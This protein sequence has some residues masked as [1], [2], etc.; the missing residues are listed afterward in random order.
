[1]GPTYYL[2]LKHLAQDKLMVH[3]QGVVQSHTQQPVKG[4]GNAG[5]L[6]L[7]EMEADCLVAHGAAFSLKER[8]MDLSDKVKV[9]VCCGC[10]HLATGGRRAPLPPQ[11]YLGKPSAIAC[12]ACGDEVPTIQVRHSAARPSSTLQRLV[13][14][15]VLLPFPGTG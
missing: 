11:G 8:H 4:K 6:R 7:G 14:L 10:F 5:G 13:P 9:A 2:R 15:S 3:G 1:M 12:K